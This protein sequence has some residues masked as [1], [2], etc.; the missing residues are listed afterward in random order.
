MCQYWALLWVPP[1]GFRIHSRR[2]HRAARVPHGGPIGVPDKGPDVWSLR[3]VRYTYGHVLL[4]F[5]MCGRMRGIVRSNCE[6][7]A[8]ERPR[9][10]R[11]RRGGRAGRLFFAWEYCN[12]RGG[13]VPCAKPPPRRPHRQA[14]LC[15]VILQHARRNG[16]V[17]FSAAAA[18]VGVADRCRWNPFRAVQKGHGKASRLSPR[19]PFERQT[20]TSPKR[21]EI[22]GLF[23]AGG[24]RRF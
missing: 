11:H 21:Q 18:A 17:R 20:L 24:G 7:C 8:A 12:M 5:C 3:R 6:A 4:V 9:A 14:F 13:T 23:R 2:A 10:R 15:S 22:V 16:P 19:G 1:N